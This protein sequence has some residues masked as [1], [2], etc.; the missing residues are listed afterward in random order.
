MAN[1]SMIDSVNFST[2]NIYDMIDNYFDSPILEKIKDDNQ[3]SI[4]M[5][6]ITSMLASVEQRYIVAITQRDNK[7]IGFKTYLN[8]LEWKSFQTRML[9]PDEKIHKIQKHSYNPKNG[10]SILIPVKLKERFNDHTDYYI[11]NQQYDEIKLTLLHKDTNNKYEYP[12][13]GTIGACLETYRTI[14]VI[15]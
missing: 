4:Y 7:P 3:V 1:Y 11:D 12:N 15:N 10:G 5:A 13:T 2:K 6:R 14:F 8:N 9:I